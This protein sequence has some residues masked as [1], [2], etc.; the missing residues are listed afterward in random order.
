MST[1][2]VLRIARRGTACHKAAR[3]WF[4][5]ALHGTPA[6]TSGE[7]CHPSLTGRRRSTAA[8]RIE[9]LWK[10][11]G[12][13]HLRLQPALVDVHQVEQSVG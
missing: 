12:Q 4:R 10:D 3:A 11:I 8:R 6:P 13:L 5:L 1:L 7:V 9:T 2:R